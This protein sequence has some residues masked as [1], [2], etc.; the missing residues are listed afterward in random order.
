MT[1]KK[2]TFEEA[3]TGLEKSVE[4]LK[5]QDTPLEAAIKCFEEGI[6]YYEHCSMILE[7]TKQKI[8]AYDR[9][10]ETVQEF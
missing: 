7:D 6:S 3:L 4:M 1:K 2:L 9:N 8:E 5:N 10:L